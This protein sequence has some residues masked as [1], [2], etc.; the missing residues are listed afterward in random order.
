MGVFLVRRVLTSIVL[1]LVSTVIMYW[2]VT[3]SGDP[4]GELYTDQSPNRDDKIQQRIQL[5]EL[6]KS[7]PER[8]W[9]W[10]TGAVQCV[11]PGQTCDLG[12]TVRGQ[13]VT[14]L[15]SQAIAST[16]SLVAA[17]VVL[18]IVLG[19]TVGI[20]SALRQYSAFDYTLTLAAFLFFSLPVFWV[21]VLLKQYAAIRLN[22]WLVEPVIAVPVI[23]VLSVL[24]GL[25]WLSV[26]GGGRRRRLIVFAAAAVATAATLAYLSAVQWFAQPALGP[27]V[28]ILAALALAVGITLISAGLRRRRVLYASLITA[29]LVSVGGVIVNEWLRTEASWPL[30]VLLALVVAALGI[31]VG[32]A[33]G[34][35]DRQAAA[36]SAAITGLL[37]GAVVYVD[38]LLRALPGY[39]DAVNGRVVATIGA[40]TPNFEGTYWET[41]LDTI[42]HLV[43]PTAALILISFATYTR[44]T[45]SS[46][47]EVSNRDFVRTARSKGV[48]ER[49][50]VVNHAFRNALIP[51]A[52]LAAIDF[53]TV[54]GGAVITETV[55]GRQGLGALLIDSV[56]NVDPNPVMG[57]YLVLAVS[58]VVFNLLADI[59]YA[60]LDPR[61]R[62][63]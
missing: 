37:A 18:A 60:Y 33:L 34:G 44:F 63:T 27:V 20:V 13:E 12:N 23:V 2:L 8:Y 6:D 46:M 54:L 62:L 42:S 1:L 24:S 25:L 10:L 56:R 45:R 21:A 50:V 39:S 28:V 47:L 4:L 52:T 41:Q 58:I 51:V 11:I 22:D 32:V 16:L 9:S 55:F 31:G 48:T 49:T 3:I 5:L 14:A 53:G 40:R 38:L 15:V 29:A 30:F 36:R 43:L 35:N 59:T 61:I 7:W 17:S 57:C 26:V 19:T